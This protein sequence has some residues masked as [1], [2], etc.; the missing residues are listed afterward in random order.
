MIRD[1]DF[2]QSKQVPGPTKEEVRCLVMCKA[3]IYQ[4]DVVLDVGCGTGGLTVES[5]QRAH[6]VIAIDKN[7][8]AVSL[9]QQ[10]L[11]KHKLLEKVKLIEGDALSVMTELTSFDVLLIG[12]SSGD[13]PQIISQGYEKLNLNGRIVVT[14]ILLETRVE[15]VETFKKLNMT[16]DVV[17]V[18][19]AKGNITD[20]GT[21]MMGRNPITIISAVKN[22][23]GN[24]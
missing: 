4:E 23:Y 18:T 22:E 24:P 2:I 7:P 19:I 12:G 13:L 21:M 1:E 15:A 8:E 3:H 20:R 10:N 14:S 11:I 6:K 9:T 16:L 5:A 17:E